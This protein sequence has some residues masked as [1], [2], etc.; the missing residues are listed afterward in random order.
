MSR[1]SD[2]RALGNIWESKAEKFLEAQGLTIVDRSYRCRLGELDIV[3][4]DGR[5]LIVVE[6]KARAK[7]SAVYSVNRRKRQRIINATR[8]F[9][10]RN[11]G[12][13][14]ANVRFD[15]IGIDAIDSDAPEY[16]WIRNAFDTV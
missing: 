12:W 5:H 6:V 14:Q 15:V 3:A 8:H 9:L 7:G 2:A 16:S 13:F 10:M 1:G 11:P 4:T